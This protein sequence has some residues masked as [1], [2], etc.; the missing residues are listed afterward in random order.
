MLPNFI[1]PGAAKC[2]T[3]ALYNLLKQHPD[4]FLSM[5]KEI[6]F[7]DRDVNYKKGIS[8]YKTK[9]F[10]KV[11]NEKIIGEITPAY[12]YL[13]YVPERIFKCLGKD[14]KFIFMLR[15]PVDRAYSHYWHTYRNGQERE[16]FIKAIEM[17]AERIKNSNNRANI[18]YSYIDRGFYSEQIRRY[19]EYF[20]KNNMK[21]ILFED[22]IKDTSRVMKEIFHFLEIPVVNNINYNILKNEFRIYRNLL[23]VKFFNLPSIKEFIRGIKNWLNSSLSLFNPEKSMN[24]LSYLIKYKPFKKPYIKLET[25]KMLNDVYYDDIKKL[26]KLINEDLSLWIFHKE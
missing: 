5:P 12:M 3:S 13:D 23:L 14:I 21:F 24:K 19:L 2:G 8:W 20:P 10:S 15:N 9:Y 7:F 17:E 25:R 11:Q 16:T 1:C 18:R 22:F 4:V 6:H 26:E